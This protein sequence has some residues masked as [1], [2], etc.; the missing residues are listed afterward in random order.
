[1]FKARR[2]P[3]HFQ[4]F[5]KWNTF[6]VC[7]FVPGIPNWWRGRLR[8]HE[9]SICT[10]GIFYL[11]FSTRYILYHSPLLPRTYRFRLGISSPE[12]HEC[13]CA[14]NVLCMFSFHSLVE[15]ERTVYWPRKKKQKI[16]RRSFGETYFGT[17][18]LRVCART[19]AAVFRIFFRP[20][21]LR[22]EVHT[23]QS[24]SCIYAYD[25]YTH[26]HI[27][28]NKVLKSLHPISI[29]RKEKKVL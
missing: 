10:L 9:I 23:R 1:M 13:E 4:L 25:K 15:N 27:Y 7:E 6:I 17:M 12:L 16:L 5:Y 28:M 2:I 29:L 26:I 8:Q 11:I 21:S 24:S 20:F 18:I 14:I 19:A 22:L 3:S